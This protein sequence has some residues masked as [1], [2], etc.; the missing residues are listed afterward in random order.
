MFMAKVFSVR[1]WW[2]HICASSSNRRRKMP[3]KSFKLLALEML[4]HRLAPAVTL[5]I[6]TANV[7]EP[8]PG[9]TALMDFTV[10]R[11]SDLNSQLTV[12][13][14]TAPGTAQAN[15]DFT[16]STGTTTFAYGSPTA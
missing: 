12:G 11:S 8:G 3:S 15:V 14:T 1:Q 16:P 10:T 2:K 4:E 7:I 9:G 6:T 5:S 13:Y